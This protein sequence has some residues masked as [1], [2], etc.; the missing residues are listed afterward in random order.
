MLVVDAVCAALGCPD[1]RLLLPTL[2][3]SELARTKPTQLLSPPF[4][5]GPDIVGF[6]PPAKSLLPP[7]LP[8]PPPLP[9]PLLL[10]QLGP[11]PA[12]SKP[13]PCCGSSK[14]GLIAPHPPSRSPGFLLSSVRS[15]RSQG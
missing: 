5:P 1:A 9:L 7:P 2:R 11:A 15:T 3:E 4:A 14:F 13:P 12:G 10:L 6:A 8:P